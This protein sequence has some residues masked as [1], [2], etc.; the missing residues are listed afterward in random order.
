LLELPRNA[1]WTLSYECSHGTYLQ[2]TE[3]PH[4]SLSHYFIFI[5]IGI[6]PEFFK[7]GLLTTAPT[8]AKT[9]E[10]VTKN[11][12]VKKL[13]S[14]PQINVATSSAAGAIVIPKGW[15]ILCYQTPMLDADARLS[16]KLALKPPVTTMTEPGKANK[17]RKIRF[18]REVSVVEIPSHRE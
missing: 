2:L 1:L 13:G 3:D 9:V 15:V 6:K 18:A 7:T 4:Y 12:T 11:Q 17:E 5:L 16:Y 14:A 8:T 10:S